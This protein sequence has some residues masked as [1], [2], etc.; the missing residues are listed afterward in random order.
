MVK[1][2]TVIAP[3][4]ENL[5]KTIGI[6]KPIHCIVSTY[7]ALCAFIG[8]NR[9]KNGELTTTCG[10]CTSYR[11]LVDAKH[12][13]PTTPFLVQ[14]IYPEKL[15]I[16]GG[17]NNI[18]GG[19]LEW[20]KECFY[21][22][23]MRTDKKLYSLMEKEAGESPPGAKGIIFLPYLLGERRPFIDSNVRGML[24]GLERFHSR[25]DIIRS[26]FEA[27]GFQ[28]R[29]ILDEFAKNNIS[30]SSIFMSGGVSNFTLVPQ[31]RADIL[32]LSVHVPQETE[33]TAL[34]AFILTLKARGLIASLKDAQEY[35]RIRKTYYPDADRH[36]AYSRLFL[37]FKELYTA[38]RELFKKR[39]TALPYNNRDNNL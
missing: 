6:K 25:K 39:I 26:V 22:S 28:A 34:G 3:V 14:H 29:L 17:S 8:S 2:G 20:A 27:T 4:K 15:T 10:T 33:T 30:V 5:S 38:N 31:L 11:M 7:D 23:S 37:L 18:E 9:Y 16:I 1:T 32:G 24:F 36:T 21:K 12:I 35:I 13:S 19:V